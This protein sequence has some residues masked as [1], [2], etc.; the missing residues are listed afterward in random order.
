MNKSNI[1]IL[2][3]VVALFVA[4]IYQ[5]ATNDAEATGEPRSAPKAPNRGKPPT[6]REDP[7]EPREIAPDYVMV[8][9]LVTIPAV[10]PPTTEEVRRLATER[11]ALAALHRFFTRQG[12]KISFCMNTKRGQ[13]FAKDLTPQELAEIDTLFIDEAAIATINNYIIS[14]FKYL[15][16]LDHLVLT[17]VITGEAD[18]KN[19]PINFDIEALAQLNL[20][21]FEA[22]NMALDNDDIDKVLEIKSI[23]SLIL[24][25]T[26]VTLD[27]LEALGKNPR[28][29]LFEYYAYNAAEI[30]YVEKRFINGKPR[31][32][33]KPKLPPELATRAAMGAAR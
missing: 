29:R 30:K 19:Q 31:L 2:L 3:V 25:G 16:D 33:K 21:T 27:Y 4:A 10:M 12:D 18:A 15:K 20:Y 11:E 8:T 7:Q 14:K 9:D 26:D 17:G 32:T 23:Q 13:L 5:T 6:I 28:L 22:Y 24:D 1:I